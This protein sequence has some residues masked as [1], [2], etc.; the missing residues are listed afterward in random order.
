MAKLA[1]PT[2]K[3]AAIMNVLTALLLKKVSSGIQMFF[4]LSES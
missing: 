1:C 3:I 2:M 4:G